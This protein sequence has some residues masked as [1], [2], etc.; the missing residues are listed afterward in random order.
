M[1]KRY[2]YQKQHQKAGMSLEEIKKECACLFPSEDV[3]YFA[4]DYLKELSTREI[5]EI[6]RQYAKLRKKN[7]I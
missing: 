7:N 2:N 6:N 4:M 5:E 1:K 3:E